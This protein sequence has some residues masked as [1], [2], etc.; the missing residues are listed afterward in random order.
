[1]TLFPHF[2]KNVP[3]YDEDGTEYVPNRTTR[4]AMKE[5]AKQAEKDSKLIKHKPVCSRNAKPNRAYE[6]Y[7]TAAFRKD[8]KRLKKRGADLSML[9]DV[10]DT[11]AGG[12]PLPIGYRDHALDGV[13]IGYRECHIRP[14]WL[15]IYQI[16]DD[17]LILRAMRTGSHSDL[18]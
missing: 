13:H 11:L 12:D 4:R 5:A 18:F 3:V 7:E 1:M 10:I 8:V 17:A 2:R 6:V 16:D 9:E 14:D 15:L